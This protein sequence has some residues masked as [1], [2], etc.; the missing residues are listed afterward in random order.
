MWR[1]PP[2]RFS[3]R[4]SRPSKTV[5]RPAQPGQARATQWSTATLTCR[6]TRGVRRGACP[7]SPATQAGSSRLLSSP[8][9]ATG[10]ASPAVWAVPSSGKG[11]RRGLSGSDLS[12]WPDTASA[13][14]VDS[15]QRHGGANSPPGTRFT[16]TRP[17]RIERLGL[18]LG[19]I[20]GQR[21]V[22]RKG[23][24]RRFRPW[25]PPRHGRSRLDAPH[26]INAVWDRRQSVSRPEAQR[27][28][29]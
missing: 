19:R 20:T 11:S 9:R 15:P 22:V 16:S 17:S 28:R 18:P 7:M 14:F 2:Q 25:G 1:I 21:G 23:T 10:P 29:T 12:G 8:R 24:L 26:A 3:G 4:S 6:F 13:C 5:V 27:R